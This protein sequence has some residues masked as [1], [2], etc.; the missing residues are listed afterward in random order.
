MK[1]EIGTNLAMTIVILCICVMIGFCG[2][3][4]YNALA[5]TSKTNIEQEN[6]ERK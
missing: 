3:T 6:H 1:V 4:Y 2:K 5:E